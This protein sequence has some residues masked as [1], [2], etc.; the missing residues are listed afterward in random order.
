MSS[1]SE[2]FFL[3]I[4]SVGRFSI[5]LK[6]RSKQCK[7]KLTEKCCLKMSNC[8]EHVFFYTYWARITYHQNKHW[9]LE[10]NKMLSA[11]NFQMLATS[12][13]L[14]K[15]NSV[16][17]HTANVCRIFFI[18][19]VTGVYLLCFFLHI[20]HLTQILLWYFYNQLNFRSS[21]KSGNCL[22]LMIECLES[23]T[24]LRIKK[25]A[26]QKTKSLQLI[27]YR[28]Q[29]VYYTYILIFYIYRSANVLAI[30]NLYTASLFSSFIRMAL[31][32]HD[33]C[34]SYH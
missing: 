30:W 28:H 16:F 7:I 34:V 27:C 3:H 22:Q 1:K 18:Q 10:Q 12:S 8:L 11:C 29:Y 2:D 19:M 5:V 21:W 33:V 15:Q 25:T 26:R 32:T 17:R 9:K 14:L 20:S 24:K 6:T 4:R 13:R 23:A 31:S